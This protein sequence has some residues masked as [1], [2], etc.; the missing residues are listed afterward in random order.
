MH[1]LENFDVHI[2]KLHYLLEKKGRTGLS[3]STK[4]PCSL[5]IRNSSPIW[6]KLTKD[7]IANDE[8]YSTYNLV[9]D[10]WIVISIEILFLYLSISI[11]FIESRTFTEKH[12]SEIFNV[13]AAI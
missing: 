9:K 1:G 7:F 6:L 12:L 13:I 8:N 2:K 5:L 10:K 4:Y 3:Y 11:Y